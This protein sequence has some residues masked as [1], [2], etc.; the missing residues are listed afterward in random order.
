MREFGYA[1]LAFSSAEEFL[2]SEYVGQTGCLVLDIAMPGMTGPELQR[3]L[4]RLNQRIPIVF[5]T[6]HGDNSTRPRMLEQGAVEC[7]SKPFSDEALLKALNA[8]FGAS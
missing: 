3:E 8:A 2:A 1:A 5:I 7:L 6:A 4:T